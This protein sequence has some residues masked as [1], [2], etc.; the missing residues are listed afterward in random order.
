MLNKAQLIQDL[1]EVFEDLDPDTTA[2]EKATQIAN[3]IDAFVKTAT[4]NT[5]VTV[6]SVS[7]VTTGLAVSGPGTGTGIGTII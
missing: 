4:V 3:A 1:K 7:G 5:T 6:A 2:L